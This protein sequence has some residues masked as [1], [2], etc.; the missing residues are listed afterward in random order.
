M[1]NMYPNNVGNQNS[2]DPY[3]FIMNNP[4]KPSRSFGPSGTAGRIA[5]VVGG[6]VLL[7]I[8]AIVLLSLL[9]KSD[10][11]QTQRLIEISQ[12]QTEIIRL[13][14][15][16]DKNAKNI[17]TRSYA[18]TTRL[19]MESSQKKT[20][21]L[22]AKRGVKEKSLAKL[23]PAGKNTK[24]D[25]LLAEAQKNNRFDETF[26]ELISKELTNYQKLLSGAAEG[27]S[28]REKE[29]LEKNFASASTIQ[30]KPKASPKPA[31]G[32]TNE[33]EDTELDEEFIDEEL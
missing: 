27:A 10:K 16:S 7:I 6:V 23:L 4:Q 32:A 25:E 30:A 12:K 11:A 2:N 17:A 31:T 14:T 8:L 1:V 33:S 22:L 13:T 19:S 15:Q 29:V 20:N 24:S 9:G 21:E 18:L 26:T 5:V 28:K 3:G